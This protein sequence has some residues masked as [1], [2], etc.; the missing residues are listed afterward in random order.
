VRIIEFRRMVHGA[1]CAPACAWAWTWSTT[2]PAASGQHPQS[3]LDRIVPGYY[4]RLD[5]AGRVE[6]ST[7]CDNTATEH[8]M[9]AKLMIDSV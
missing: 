4:H 2:T 7:C 8:R 9:M 3:V 6:R 1:A 5:A